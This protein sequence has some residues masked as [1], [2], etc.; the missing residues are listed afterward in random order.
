VKP[1]PSPAL[2][3]VIYPAITPAVTP[4]GLQTLIALADQAGQAIMDIYQ[5]ASPL[6]QQQKSDSSP[7]TEADLAANAI[8]VAGLNAHWPHIPVLSEENLN[9]FGPQEQPPL[10][11]AVDPLDGTKEFIKRN[12]EFTVNVALVVNGEPQIGVVGAPAQGLM[13]VGCAGAQWQGAPLA[14][15]RSAEGWV[16]IR[17]SGYEPGSRVEASEPAD[18][19][20]PLRVAMSRSHP[21]AELAA[22]LA[23]WGAIEARDVG[24]SLKFC[25]VAEGAVDVYPRLGPTCIWD[26]AAGHAL[27]AA[28]G[29]RV[30]QLD[31]A[32]L[33]YATPAQTLNPFFVVWGQG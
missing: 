27:V 22:W 17:V 1:T 15:K 26:T 10:Y 25:L 29:G 8:L 16:D 7:L 9:Q 3:P 14:R 24:S 30:C 4:E 28:A 20:R 12:G 13:H 32:P 11:W 19:Q 2:N 6:Q 18:V 33:H 31:G 23:P 21:S 5:R